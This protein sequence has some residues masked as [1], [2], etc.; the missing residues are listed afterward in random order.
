MV[1]RRGN[2]LLSGSLCRLSDI[3]RSESQKLL[4]ECV[5]A[6]RANWD[7]QQK[8]HTGPR[9]GKVEVRD[10][11]DMLMNKPRHP[12]GEKKVQEINRIAVS[13]NA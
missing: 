7:H 1:A 6:E 2:L 13:P 11:H 10:I 4:F 8:Y 3:P 5:I 12:K 9:Q